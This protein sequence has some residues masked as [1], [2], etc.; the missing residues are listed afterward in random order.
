MFIRVLGEVKEFRMKDRNLVVCREEELVPPNST[1]KHY[2]GTSSKKERTLM[3]RK[4]VGGT[5]NT[6]SVKT[7][8]GDVVVQGDEPPENS[9]PYYSVCTRLGHESLA[10]LLT[11][12]SHESVQLTSILITASLLTAICGT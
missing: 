8:E 7:D 12:S 6:E 4:W 10:P 11:R 9:R 3:K 1:D 2:T 5:K